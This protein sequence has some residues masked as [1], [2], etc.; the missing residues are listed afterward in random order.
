MELTFYKGTSENIPSGSILFNSSNQ[1]IYLKDGDKLICYSANKI[2][3]KVLPEYIGCGT[4]YGPAQTVKLNSDFFYIIGRAE[5]LTLNLPEGAST[6][7]QEYCC[8][9]Y[10]PSSAF[11]L[12]L[13]TGC[14]YQEGI[15]PEFTENTCYQLVVL[16]NCVTWGKFSGL[17]DVNVDP[18]SLGTV[19][20]DSHIIQ[21][22]DNHGLSSGTYTLK[23]IDENNSPLE[24]FRNISTFTI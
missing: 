6:D 17:P 3:K 24:S 2:P 1:K 15:A 22:N 18:N 14:V 7:C 4:N 10:C 8:Q 9:F 23:Y 21:L 12:T 5:S 20:G 13:P 11:T 16:N 19:S